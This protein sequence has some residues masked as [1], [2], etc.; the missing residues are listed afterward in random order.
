[1]SS[2]CVAGSLKR[3]RR[4]SRE[5]SSARSSWV[6]EIS[7]SA[8]GS[9]SFTSEQWQQD[10]RRRRSMDKIVVYCFMT[11]PEASARVNVRLARVKM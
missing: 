8:T 2:S 5:T 11:V 9:R 1:M 6:D 7:G 4:S 3:E 10:W